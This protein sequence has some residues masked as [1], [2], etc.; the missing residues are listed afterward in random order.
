M[1]STLSAVVK[2][3]DDALNVLFVEMIRVSLTM[4]LD[5]CKHRASQQN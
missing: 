3:K 2:E 5:N 4:T 1:Y